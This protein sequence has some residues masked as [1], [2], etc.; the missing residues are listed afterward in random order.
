[1]ATVRP[2]VVF[3]DLLMSALFTAAAII[4]GQI[5]RVR[6]DLRDMVKAVMAPSG[7]TWNGKTW[8]PPVAGPERT[9]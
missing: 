8:M 5:N 3:L 1:M 7:W 6:Q 4:V 2:H 9:P